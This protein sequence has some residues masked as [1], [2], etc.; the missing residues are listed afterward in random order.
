MARAVVARAEV[1]AAGTA[2]ARVAGGR[3]SEC[4]VAAAVGCLGGEAMAAGLTALRE[5]DEVGGGAG[6]AVQEELDLDVT[7]AGRK[8]GG[9]VDRQGRQDG[10]NG[11]HGYGDLERVEGDREFGCGARARGGARSACWQRV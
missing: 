7:H 4:S 9:R 6:H 3:G 11:E 10:G 8:R 2:L 1:T 5:V